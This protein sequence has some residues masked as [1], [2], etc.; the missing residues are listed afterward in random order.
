M[1]S[2]SP[3]I[4]V[5]TFKTKRA[6]SLVEVV[7]SIG[8]VTFSAL[9]IFSLM[10]V[11]LSSLQATSRQLVE[12][13]IFGTL[14]AEL[15]STPFSEISNHIDT[16]FPVY[17]DGEGSEVSEANLSSFTVECEVSSDPVNSELRRATF[18]IAGHAHTSASAQSILLVNKGL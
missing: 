3:K 1:T 16:R 9:V 4:F 10:P 13:E 17:F 2:L 18:L 15:Y 12:T 8:L 14:S 11:G 5:G 7:L 6:F